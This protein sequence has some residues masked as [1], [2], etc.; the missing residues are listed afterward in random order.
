MES[1]SGADLAMKTKL[2]FLWIDDDPRRTRSSL[3]LERSIKVIVN[4][5][6]VKGKEILPII[7][8]VGSGEALP[9][10]VLIDHLLDKISKGERGIIKYGSGVAEIIRS[11]LGPSQK[12]QCPIVGVTA[13]IKV[14]E[15]SS[16]QEKFRY[17]AIV[18]FENLSEHYSTLVSLAK[19][20]AILR[21]ARISN[22]DSLLTLL[23]PPEEDRGKL[24]GVVPSGLRGDYTAMKP[25]FD[26]SR[27]V[28]YTLLRR[29]GFLYD[30][31]WTATI[32]G[33]KLSALEKVK[34]IIRN[35]EYKGIFGDAT[36]P[37]WWQTT[38]RQILFKVYSGEPNLDLRDL[39]RALKP[40]KESDFSVCYSCKQDK[41]DLVGYTDETRKKRV[42]L[43]L[44]CSV[45]SEKAQ[46]VPFFEEERIMGD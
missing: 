23:K 34:R 11:R 41:P 5:V 46:R 45:V 38:L 6:D 28:R 4:F 3:A 35:A 9:D 7:Q 25:I 17:D 13:A 2:N 29:A 43:H 32:L 1:R 12:K 22:L 44:R 33:L 10:L 20:Y 21:G 16:F 26:Y 8:K 36:E 27:W 30:D 14:G 19:G 18:P 39:G 37:R 42:Q 40:V 24:Y 15:E 31:L